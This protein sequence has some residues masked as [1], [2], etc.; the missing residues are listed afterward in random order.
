MVTQIKINEDTIYTHVETLPA[1]PGD[2]MRFLERNLQ[3]PESAIGIEVQGTVI[4]Q[5]IVDKEGNL[6][7]VKTLN[8]PGGRLAE[9]AVGII[10]KSPAWRP[11]EQNGRRV[12]YLHVQTITFRLQ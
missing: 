8:N 4:V 11:A 7:E 12:K 5:F 10:R 3:Y 6:S 9:E 1:F 2:W